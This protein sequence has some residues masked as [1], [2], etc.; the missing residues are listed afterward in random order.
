MAARSKA[1]KQMKNSFVNLRFEPLSSKWFFVRI[2]MYSSW[3]VLALS[4]ARNSHEEPEH[5]ATLNQ[6]RKKTI[7]YFPTL[8]S[9]YQRCK[10]LPFNPIENC[11]CVTHFCVYLN[12]QSSLT[13]LLCLIWIYLE[14]SRSVTCLHLI[15]GFTIQPLILANFD[16]DYHWYL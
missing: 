14:N 15:L 13:I 1:Q 11:H 3:L 8:L 10:Y 9:R 12:T 2:K 7:F 6:S 4:K 16:L 5:P